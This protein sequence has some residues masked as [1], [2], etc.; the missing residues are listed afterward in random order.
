MKDILHTNVE[1][2]F[3]ARGLVVGD[4]SII[5]ILALALQA[6]RHVCD[7]NLADVL[8]VVDLGLVV[9]AG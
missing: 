8:I 1:V 3:L 4:S 2:C 5:V 6:G 7:I 9:H